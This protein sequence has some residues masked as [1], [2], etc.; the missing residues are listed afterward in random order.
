MVYAG[1]P[2]NMTEPLPIKHG[3]GHCLS[4]QEH[5]FFL[6]SFRPAAAAAQ[7]NI[8]AAALPA[9]GLP[10]GAGAVSEGAS[11]CAASSAGVSERTASSASLSA[12]ISS[13]EDVVP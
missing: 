2:G 9:E 1:C 13:K 4:W 10:V 7:M 11:A 12:A 5:H 6:L 8:T 3:S